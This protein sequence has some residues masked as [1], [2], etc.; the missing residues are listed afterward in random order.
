MPS[1]PYAWEFYRATAS[2]RKGKSSYRLVDCPG[3]LLRR[4]NRI[5]RDGKGPCPLG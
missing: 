4:V 1:T 3:T 5:T 2:F